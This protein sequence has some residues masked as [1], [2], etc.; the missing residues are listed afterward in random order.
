MRPASRPRQSLLCRSR[1][2]T[3]AASSPK[4]KVSLK[5]LRVFLFWTA[6]VLVGCFTSSQH[7]IF[8]QEFGS[9][10]SFYR[11]SSALELCLGVKHI[12][13]ITHD[14]LAWLLIRKNV[15]MRCFLAAVLKVLFQFCT[16]THVHVMNASFVGYR[17]VS[18]ETHTHRPQPKACHN[19]DEGSR[20]IPKSRCKTKFEMHGEKERETVRGAV[21]MIS[22]SLSCKPVSFLC[23]RF[24]IAGIWVSLCVLA[25]ILPVIQPQTGKCFASGGSQ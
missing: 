24:W 16:T 18:I 6:F 22:Q 2:G 15:I 9:F 8:C 14:G 11:E 23:S 19:E 25:E 17:C 3:G 4:Q 5:L 20:V 7:H 10:C 1:T 13:H 21:N 12:P